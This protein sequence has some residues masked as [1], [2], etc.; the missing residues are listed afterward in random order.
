VAF[1]RQRAPPVRRVLDQESRRLWRAIERVGVRRT[2]DVG[3]SR[4]CRIDKPV[5]AEDAR[6][7]AAFAESTFRRAFAESNAAG[8]MDWHCSASF[9]EELQL[10]EFRDP[11]RETWLAEVEGRLAGYV[12]LRIDARTA[13]VEGRKPIETQR[14]CLDPSRH[15]T[16]LAH[17]LNMRRNLQ[18]TR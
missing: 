17:D 11:D 12:H 16:G 5:P 10:A 18:T 15:G 8:N 9:G 13:C 2:D 1:A 4:E 14:F 3:Q 7:L 6:D